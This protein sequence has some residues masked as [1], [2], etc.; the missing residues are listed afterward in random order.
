MRAEQVFIVSEGAIESPWFFFFLLG[1]AAW[2]KPGE[3]K[4]SFA[5]SFNA[6]GNEALRG[7]GRGV[8]NNGRSQGYS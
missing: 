7:R 8:S 3:S 5:D 6:R 2:E 4:R 1:G